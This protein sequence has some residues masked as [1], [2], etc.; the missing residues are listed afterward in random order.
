[1]ISNEL[2]IKLSEKIIPSFHQA[3]RTAD[4]YTFNVFKGGVIAESQK[5]NKFKNN[6]RNDEKSRVRIGSKK[7]R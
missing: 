5:H 6:N 2:T 7:S 1:M 3:W 4:N